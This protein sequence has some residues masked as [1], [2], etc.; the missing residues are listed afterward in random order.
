MDS[1]FVRSL[2]E[3][4]RARHARIGIGIWNADAKLITS[5]QSATEYADLLLVGDPCCDC[6]LDYV[7]S[8][9]PWKELVR[10]LAASE[11]E[12]AV[13][14]NLPA[15]RTMR[16]VAEQ[17]Q[18]RVRRL[19]LLEL[20]GW[21]F[22]LG[23]VG[24]DEGETL[25]DRLE[26]LLGG[27]KFLQ[28]MGVRPRGAVLSG[29][30]MEDMGRCERVDRSLAEGELIAA[31]AQEAGLQA[32]HKGILIESCRGDDIVIA[33]DGICGNLIFRTLLLLCGAQSYGAPVLMDQIFV[34]SSRARG[35]FDGPV[36]LASAM[37]GMREKRD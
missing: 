25:P 27:A 34:D 9:E 19:A 11:I 16:A 37:A 30:R 18:I 31:R 3:K 8:K 13:R 26:L 24:I 15:G 5:L 1:I 20:S 32:R 6:A 33:P 35:S 7:A 10:L 14:G 21:A 2:R 22:L 29:G 4:A 23:P 12:G 28:S 36:M 17:F